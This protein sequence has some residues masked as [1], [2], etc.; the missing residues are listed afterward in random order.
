LLEIR[1]QS[2]DVV[3]EMEFFSQPRQ[4][5][6]TLPVH[7]VHSVQTVQSVANKYGAKLQQSQDVGYQPTSQKQK[8]LKSADEQL[9]DE[10]V[11]EIF[12][13]DLVETKMTSQKQGNGQKMSSLPRGDAHG[14]NGNVNLTANQSYLISTLCAVNEYT[15]NKNQRYLDNVQQTLAQNQVRQKVQTQS[16]QQLQHS[17]NRVHHFQQNG[18]QECQKYMMM[19]QRQQYNASMNNQQYMMN[20]QPVQNRQYVQQQ[21]MQYMHRAQY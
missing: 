7:N 4:L 6:P 20:Q 15:L 14:V 16:G 12:D 17:P 9:I 13:I 18:R 10:I 5:T 8:T 3:A 19:R 1:R 21:P 11:E 2:T